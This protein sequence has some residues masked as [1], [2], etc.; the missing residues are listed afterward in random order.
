MVVLDIL[1]LLAAGS[2]ASSPTIG[3]MLDDRRDSANA[4][5]VRINDWVR[6]SPAT[7]FGLPPTAFA[8]RLLNLVNT[9][10][11]L[12]QGEYP[13]C[14]PAAFLN[15]MLRRFP[16]NV[17]GFALD[18]YTTGWAR[19]GNLAVQTS[20][21]LRTFDY[22]A[23]V[24]G[25]YQ[26]KLR[27]NEAPEDILRRN[28]DLFLHAH[29]DWLLLAGI[30][31]LTRPSEAVTG[32]LSEAE[33]HGHLARGPSGIATLAD[34]L[35]NLFRGCGLY[36]SAAKLSDGDKQD[37]QK[38]IAALSRSKDE[39]DVCLLSGMPRFIGIGS[40][41]HAVRLVEPPIIGPNT[42]N[43]GSPEKDEDIKFKF[44]SWGFKPVSIDY[45]KVPFDDGENAFTF[46]QTRETFA[47][48][49]IVRAVPK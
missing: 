14:L 31:Q 20:G 6:T 37:K 18:L 25:E 8:E 33:E 13:W 43:S 23:A 49:L 32:R 19:L 40:G 16:N 44:W 22:P 36:A 26:R 7:Q 5:R 46:A 3:K 47:R 24:E 10:Q 17:V 15:P 4:A 39:E 11:S 38:L 30:E 34:D 28:R 21:E 35:I 29:T 1:L 2:P 12:R 41:G 27:E 48:F 9:P 45:T 42:A